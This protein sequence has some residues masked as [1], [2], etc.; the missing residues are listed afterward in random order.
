MKEALDRIA[1]A[2]ER[3][4]E[5]HEVSLKRLVGIDALADAEDERTVEFQANLLKGQTELMEQL[6]SYDKRL[7]AFEA[8]LTKLTEHVNISQ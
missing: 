3:N 2:V 8:V 4:N 6:A 1:K 5:L 7:G